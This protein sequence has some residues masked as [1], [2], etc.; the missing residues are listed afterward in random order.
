MAKRIN[1]TNRDIL[2]DV[3]IRNQ[4]R[5][6]QIF[7]SVQKIPTYFGSTDNAENKLKLRR[8]KRHKELVGQ[9]LICDIITGTETLAMQGTEG[10][11]ITIEGGENIP[12]S[13]HPTI[14]KFVKTCVACS[15]T[16]CDDYNKVVAAMADGLLKTIK[17]INLPIPLPA[18]NKTQKIIGE[19]LNDY[20]KKICEE[21]GTKWYEVISQPK[22][23]RKAS[24]KDLLLNAAKSSD[25]TS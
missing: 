9:P 18:D 12:T 17:S 7:E 10:T 4:A 6:E 22:T 21:T 2:D 20:L 15:M 1:V 8:T 14:I 25:T 5:N 13:V 16:Q 11:V 3:V 24:G 23:R 19:E